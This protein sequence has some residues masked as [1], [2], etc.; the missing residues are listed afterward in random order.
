MTMLFFILLAFSG[1]LFLGLKGKM[2]FLKKY[3]LIPLLT[4]LLL[5]SMGTEI[6]SSK[7]IV[8]NLS[9]IGLHAFVIALFAV[10]GSF[11]ITFIVGRLLIRESGD[12]DD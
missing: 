7:E 1:G 10:A 5:F 11:A 9:S 2:R 6:G 4:V 3:K 8:D 12:K